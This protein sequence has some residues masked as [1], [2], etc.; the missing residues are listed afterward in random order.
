MLYNK[1]RKIESDF[2]LGMVEFKDINLEYNFISEIEGEVFKIGSDFWFLKVF[3][4]D[5]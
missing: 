4:F 3:V 2:V 5:F 1:F